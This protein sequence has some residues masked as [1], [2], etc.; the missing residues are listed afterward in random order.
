LQR[1]EER[2]EKVNAECS[3]LKARA[4]LGDPGRQ[5]RLRRQGLQQLWQGEKTTVE[6]MRLSALNGLEEACRL[7]DERCT[8]RLRQIR[9]GSQQA[10]GLMPVDAAG[11]SVDPA[12]AVTLH[13]T[14]E[15]ATLRRYLDDSR[16]RHAPK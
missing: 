12:L 1:C 13:S 14:D 10:T 3:A 8:I 15:A 6:L 11:C 9:E 16:G 4:A 2:A 5:Q 7:A